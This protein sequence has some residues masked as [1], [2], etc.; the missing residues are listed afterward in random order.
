MN[1]VHSWTPTKVRQIGRTYGG[2][3]GKKKDDF[4]KGDA[5]YVTFLGVL[6]NTA[7]GREAT[8]QVNVG[9]HETQNRVLKGDLLFNGTSETPGELAMGAVVRDDIP[10]LFLNSFCFGLRLHDP[11]EHYAP[12]L[13]YL[14]RGGPGRAATRALAQG[15]TRYNISKAQF[16]QVTFAIPPPGEQRAIAE[17]LSDADR[18]LDSL[19]ALIA[20]KRDI[21]AS[22]MQ[23]LL[24]GKSRLPGF[25]SEWKAKR[26]SEIGRMLPTANN[27]RSE[28]NEEG[29]VS[30][31]H[32][33]DIHALARCV[34]DCS[35]AGLPRIRANRVGSATYLRDGDL[36]M[37]DASEDLSG[38]GKSIE[39]QKVGTRTVVAGLH[40]ILYRGIEEHWAMGFKAYL[41][42]IPTF[43]LALQRLATGISVYGISKKRVAE[44]ELSLPSRPE[45][46]AIVAVLSSM[47][48]EI[49]AL[50]QR[51]DKTRALKQGMMQ[52]LLTGRT[53][54]VETQA[55]GG[56]AT[57]S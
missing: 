45:Q 49:E 35:R 52:Q 11:T 56:E 32:Y 22:V 37:V 47:D 51:R 19:G 46:K 24:T 54:L 10:N 38:V 26:L 18:L 50:E 5:L 20:K 4:G 55:T 21:K 30:Y 1:A 39:V 12:F 53:R 13:A 25:R 23:Q 36:V 31:I 9:V 41:Q 14:S 43:R 42:F 16:R 17:L 2:L 7:V 15:A 40:T 29:S 44:I 57:A 8:S 3:S 6:E 33:G 34:L 27:T 28:L 48:A